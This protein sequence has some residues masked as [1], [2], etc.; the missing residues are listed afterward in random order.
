MMLKAR[1]FAGLRIIAAGAAL[2]AAVACDNPAGV[3][4]RSGHT[5]GAG[6]EHAVIG[7]SALTLDPTVKNGRLV[8]VSLAHAEAYMGR[9]SGSTLATKEAKYAGFTSLRVYLELNDGTTAY[10]NDG[11]TRDDFAATDAFLSILNEDGEVQI[12][13]DVW[14]VT[15]DLVYRVAASDAGALA[16]A[17]PTLSTT[18]DGSTASRG[19][20]AVI[21]SQPVETTYSNPQD[22]ETAAGSLSPSYAA[23]VGSLGTTAASTASPTCHV[24]APNTRYRMEGVSFISN[25]WFYS[26]AGVK[27]RW[28][29][30]K[31]TWFGLSSKWVNQSQSGRLSHSVSATTWTSDPVGG[32]TSPVGF[33]YY[34][35]ING[36]AELYTQVRYRFG[37]GL[38]MYGDVSATHTVANSSVNGTCYTFVS[39]R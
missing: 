22:V 1:S 3:A 7:E 37:I 30:K 33:D 39:R 23:P 14:K 25:Y 9:L 31:S 26:E 35:W 28:Q 8:F 20:G 17:V 16:T 6:A 10:A 36:G 11:V 19:T 21:E 24:Y 15:R 4:S 2:A 27:T 29:Y 12:G 38:R 13:S 32:H 18:A 5:P 34:D